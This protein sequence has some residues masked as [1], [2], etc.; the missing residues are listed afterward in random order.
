VVE[1]VGRSWAENWRGG[2]EID[3]GGGGGG[4]KDASWNVP[5]AKGFRALQGTDGLAF[6]PTNVE[7]PP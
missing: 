7:V 3:G 5:P 2:L 1:E 6:E 4:W